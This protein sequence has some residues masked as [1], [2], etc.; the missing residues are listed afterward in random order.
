MWTPVPHA[1]AAVD[2]GT[3]PVLRSVAHPR[4]LPKACIVAADVAAIVLT[5]VLAYVVRSALKGSD[6]TDCNRRHH[7]LGDVSLP[8]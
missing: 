1:E 7:L 8:D 4:W 6:A 3:A 2:L 5:M